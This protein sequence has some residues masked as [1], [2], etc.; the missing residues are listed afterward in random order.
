MLR[1]LAYCFGRVSRKA[2]CHQTQQ[3]V[4]RDE[5]GKDGGREREDKTE[6][7]TWGKKRDRKWGIQ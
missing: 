5:I 4:E 1:P 3:E 2:K 6:S 7:N